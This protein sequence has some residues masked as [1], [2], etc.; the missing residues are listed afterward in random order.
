MNEDLLYVTTEDDSEN[1]WVIK[2]DGFFKQK[3][4]KNLL[5]SMTQ[6]AVDMTFSNAVRIL[7][8]CPNPYGNE[9]FA[10]TGIVIGKVQSGKTS[11]FISVSSR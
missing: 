8:H 1:T 7:S 6:D 10:K 5:Q 11:N 4:E 3:V 9:Q 2:S